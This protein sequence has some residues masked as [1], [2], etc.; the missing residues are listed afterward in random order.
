MKHPKQ[1]VKTVAAIA[2]ILGCASAVFAAGEKERML[3]RVPKI[4]ALKNA[5]IVGETAKGLLGFV[6]ESPDPENKELVDAEN[7]DR[8]AVY[9]AIAAKQ[10]VSAETVAKRRA[11]QLAKQATL[12]DWLQNENGEWIQKK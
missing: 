11:L 10:G 5:G 6:N 2:L 7:K 4:E 3:E 9:E 8:T 1:I 12:G